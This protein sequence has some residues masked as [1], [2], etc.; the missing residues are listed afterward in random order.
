[1]Y[2]CTF[3]YFLCFSHVLLLHVCQPN[4]NVFL[5]LSRILFQIKLY[6]STQLFLFLFFGFFKNSVLSNHALSEPN[7]ASHILIELG[8]REFVRLNDA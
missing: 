7:F 2:N 6:Q 5:Y 8:T 3:I 4:W 1:M